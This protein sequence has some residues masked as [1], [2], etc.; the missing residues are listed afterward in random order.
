MKYE[1]MRAD[2]VVP[3]VCWVTR[4][5]LG[6][7]FW[8]IPGPMRL[9]RP[10]RL[11]AALLA[12]T[13]TLTGFAPLAAHLCAHDEAPMAMHGEMATH[14]ALPT[15]HAASH[16]ADHACC[17][18]PCD[19]AAPEE[20]PAHDDAC[21]VISPAAPIEEVAI[22][23]PAAPRAE[24]VLFA[25]AAPDWAE[26]VPAPRPAPVPLDTGPPAPPVRSHLAVSV[27]LI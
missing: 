3:D 16:E 19:P 27:L 1:D 13:L 4:V 5:C 20:A 26:V 9:A 22:V 18:A 23:A 25:V 17:P 10:Y 12:V 24:A 15:T 8:T 11:A 21:C 7:T 14:H 6:R 2:F